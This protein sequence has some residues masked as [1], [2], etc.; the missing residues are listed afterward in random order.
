MLRTPVSVAIT[1]DQTVPMMTTNSIAAFGLPKPKQGERNPADARQRL[2]PQRQHADRVFHE[3]EGGG[4][5]PERK[6]DRDADEVTNEQPPHG[7][8]GGL[9]QSPVAA[10]RPGD[11]RRRSCGDGKRTGD[12]TFAFTTKCQIATRMTK[13]KVARR[14]RLISRIPPRRSDLSRRA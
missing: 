5:Q 8:D 12:Q 14:V 6:S 11:I 10:P 9:K 4:E 13:N 2:K 3:L 7:H 1:T